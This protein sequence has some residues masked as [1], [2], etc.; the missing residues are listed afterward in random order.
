M[1]DFIGVPDQETSKAC[2]EQTAVDIRIHYL[3][4]HEPESINFQLLRL[5]IHD[6]MAT[7]DFHTVY[8]LHR[9]V[10]IVVCIIH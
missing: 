2:S 9:R 6:A 3:G 8:K 7:C 5:T 1:M 10:A 4:H